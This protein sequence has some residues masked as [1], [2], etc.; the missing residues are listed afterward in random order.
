MSD[1]LPSLLI[2]SIILNI[3]I[4]SAGSVTRCSFSHGIHLVHLITC[5]NRRLKT[6]LL[7]LASGGMRA[8]E[9]LTIRLKDIDFSV[10]PTKIHR[11][12]LN[13]LSFMWTEIT[14]FYSI[15][16]FFFFNHNN[17]L[18]VHTL[19]IQNKPFA[20]ESTFLYSL[21]LFFLTHF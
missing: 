17:K 10:N 6:Y 15:S 4:I 2:R 16:S 13:L 1:F 20:K 9:A 12:V 11:M 18:I 14:I 3:T 7:I 5:N 21:C 19:G 8:T